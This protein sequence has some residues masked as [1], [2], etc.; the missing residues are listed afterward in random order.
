MGVMPE[1]VGT[2]AM[3]CSLQRSTRRLVAGLCACMAVA[4][5]AEVTAPTLDA[6]ERAI[7]QDGTSM[8]VLALETLAQVRADLAAGQAIPAYRLGSLISKLSEEAKTDLTADRERALRKIDLALQLATQW[9]EDLAP[10]SSAQDDVGHLLMLRWFLR[11]DD[12]DR[13]R[14]HE[15]FA[16]S[17]RRA[18]DPKFQGS[19]AYFLGATYEGLASAAR[20]MGLG[21]AR[22]IELLRAGIAANKAGRARY[23]Q[24]DS[25]VGLGAL[26]GK[27]AFISGGSAMPEVLDSWIADVRGLPAETQAKEGASLADALFEQGRD[28]EA[29][30]WLARYARHWA[31]AQVPPAL[32]TRFRAS[33][34]QN[35]S[36]GR[37]FDAFQARAPEKA[38]AFK[39]R[40]CAGMALE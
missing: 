8:Q 37:G 24:Y 13:Q 10:W 2:G 23:P 4:A 31:S 12:A 20:R 17:D 29:V 15:V 30:D 11:G 21:R 22:E 1:R 26:Y 19:S 35:L 9:R 7:R 14:A 27:F 39:T 16:E 28:E 36:L 38:L 6:L 34:C 32:A 40:I 5:H 3:A 25:S 18:S 33:R